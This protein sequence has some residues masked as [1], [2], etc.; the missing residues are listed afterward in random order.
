MTVSFF[1]TMEK[2]RVWVVDVMRELGLDDERR[3]L[4]ALRAGLHA[5]RDRLP[6]AEAVDLGAQLPML[7][8]GLYYEGWRL[9]DRPVRV[10]AREDF[11]E[12]VRYHLNGDHLL[13]P[14]GVLRA[15]TRALSRHI[16]TGELRQVMNAMP[17]HLSDFLYEKGESNPLGRLVQPRNSQS[18]FGELVTQVER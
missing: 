1:G 9:A 6:P 14:L 7:L 13:D 17:R 10:R 12:M 2:T 15:V 18:G 5:I 8:R 11:L 3:A 16:S 4:R